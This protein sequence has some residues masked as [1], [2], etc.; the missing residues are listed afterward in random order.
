MWKN[1]A[2]TYPLSVSDFSHQNIITMLVWFSF[3]ISTVSVMMQLMN[4]ESY[5]GRSL[6]N[7]TK[8]ILI[9]QPLNCLPSIHTRLSVFHFLQG[10]RHFQGHPQQDWTTS[11]VG[12]HRCWFILVTNVL[13]GVPFPCSSRFSGHGEFDGYFKEQGRKLGNWGLSAREKNFECFISYSLFVVAKQQ[14]CNDKAMFLLNSKSCITGGK[15]RSY[16]AY[17]NGWHH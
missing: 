13:Y 2:I 16:I 5:A 15:F 3:D 1:V 14:I 12:N 6:R 9:Y 7:N 11:N 10:R 17:S 4:W 8:S